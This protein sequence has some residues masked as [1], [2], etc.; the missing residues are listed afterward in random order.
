MSPGAQGNPKG[1]S[2]NTFVLVGLPLLEAF[3]GFKAEKEA[4][5]NENEDGEQHPKPKCLPMQCLPMPERERVPCARFNNDLWSE[6]VS[7]W[8]P[9]AGAIGDAAGV[10]GGVAAFA[11]PAAAAAAATR[12]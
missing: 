1:K 7:Q 8:V 11:G 10:A 12:T 9:L 5:G 6:R 2:G 3:R 4:K